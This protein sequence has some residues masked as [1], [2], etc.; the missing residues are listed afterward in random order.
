MTIAHILVA[1][2]VIA[3]TIYTVAATILQLRAPDALTRA[4]LLG[5]LVVNA[6]PLLILAKLIYSWSTVG[7]I[8][9]DLLRAVIAI[10][11]V[12]IVGSVGSFVMGRSIYGVTVTDP[13]RTDSGESV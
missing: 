7:F 3:A 2:L 1:I 11:G 6:I 9:G 8:I 4:N 13:Q 5:T 10:L 12:W